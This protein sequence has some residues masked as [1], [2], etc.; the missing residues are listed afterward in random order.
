MLRK[1][2]KVQP[3]PTLMREKDSRILELEKAL[4]DRDSEIES[5][6]K[7]YYSILEKYAI[8]PDRIVPVATIIQAFDFKKKVLAEFY[9]A[10]REKAEAKQT[11][12]FLKAERINSQEIYG[13]NDFERDA[14]AREVLPREYERLDIASNKYD[15]AKYNLE[16]AELE[17]DR[18][19]T[20]LSLLVEEAIH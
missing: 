3:N 10:I 16:M 9:N 7:D 12:E 4:K 8:K 17:I 14:R 5:I 6:K 1:G 11:L 15:L 2:R 20:I 19:K 13:K 18:I